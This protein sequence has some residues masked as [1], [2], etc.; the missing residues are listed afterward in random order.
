MNDTHADPDLFQI[1]AHT[2]L[3]ESLTRVLK[4][5][6]TF[7]IFEA[8]GDVAP[9]MHQ[10]NGV[11]HEGTRFL[12]RLEL[13]LG[14]TRPLLLSSTVKKDNLLLAVDLTN[15]DLRLGGDHVPQGML[16]LF[17][18]KFLW[19]GVCYERVKVT[20]Y[21]RDPLTLS[22]SFRFAADFLDIFE[23]RGMPRARRGRIL[24]PEIQPHGA[25]LRYL[26]LDG[27]QRRT[28]LSFSPVP[29]TVS[30]SEARFNLVLAPRAEQVLFVCI[31][32]EAG[33]QRRHLLSLS[34]IHI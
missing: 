2:S 1:E 16:H 34:L 8:H 5:G 9:S 22:L 4:Q 27:V 15:P 31:G 7:G 25:V 13:G 33:D 24:S 29:D 3:A 21:A 20:S 17:R 26:G 14:D 11:F 23:L 10:H 28:I 18:S 12:S 19:G 32:F 6:D 30:G